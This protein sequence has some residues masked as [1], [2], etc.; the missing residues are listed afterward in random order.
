MCK[1]LIFIGLLLI[2]VLM[3]SDSFAQNIKLSGLPNTTSTSGD[4]ILVSVPDGGD[5]VSRHIT[6]EDF[7]A[8]LLSAGN[9]KKNTQVIST[10]SQ[11]ITFTGASL[12]SASY[13]L[14]Y[15]SYD[16]AG[17]TSPIA[18]TLKE[19]DGFTVNNELGISLTVEYI[20]IEL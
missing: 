4:L 18:I 14:V 13:V 1:R 9:L 17:V 20:A 11:K 7:I 16:A 12:G 15:K 3:G 19:T 5:Y 6:Y 2:L 10:G 8:D